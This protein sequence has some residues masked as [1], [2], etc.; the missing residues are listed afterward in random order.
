MGTPAIYTFKGDSQKS[1]QDIHLVYHSDG[2]PSGAADIIP[3]L[4]S[5]ACRIWAGEEVDLESLG[6]PRVDE[7]SRLASL[8]QAPHSTPFR[9][10]IEMVNGSPVMVRALR[11]DPVIPEELEQRLESAKAALEAVELEM[12]AAR[13]TPTYAELAAGDLDKVRALG[14]GDVDEE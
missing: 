4:A 14:N 1:Q 12:R 10:E 13:N 5:V 7:A 3:D 6:L 8:E 11:H 2:Y 9:Y